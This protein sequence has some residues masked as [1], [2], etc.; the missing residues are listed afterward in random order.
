MSSNA[1]AVPESVCL[2]RLS[3][4]GDTCHV[5]PLLRSLQAAWPDTHFT[6][7]IGSTE[8]KLMRLIP[9]VELIEY[10]KRTGL[11][12]L[13]ALRRRLQRR[14]FDVLLDLQ[15]S[16]RA[17]AVSLCIRAHR[18]IGFD[19]AR[20]REMQWLFTNERVAARRN[21][22]VLDSFLGFADALGVSTRVNDWTLPL[23]VEALAR[24][25]ELVPADQLTLVISPCASHPLRNWSAGRYAQVADHAARHQG[26]RVL[27]CGGRS[28][29]ERAM[30]DAILAHAR[31][32]PVDLVGRDTLPEL[33]A[34]LARATVLLSPDSG[35]VHMATLVNTPVIGLYA[36]TRVQR[37]GPYRSRHWCVD[38]YEQAAQQFLARAPQQLEWTRKIE[39]P[40]VMDLI[41]VE[42]VVSQLNRLVVAASMGRAA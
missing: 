15:H 10:D 36:A 13:L 2:L 16:L 9:G 38:A 17:S 35:P 8:A 12:G 41:S 1:S 22:H 37:S 25:R 5:V 27:L 6:W 40:G 42:H 11:A 18:R 31:T 32:G 24:A 33:L 20:A 23:S 3:A 39:K 4:I 26:M 19:R 30:A 7:V 21:E 34:V 29:Q 28:P 14:K